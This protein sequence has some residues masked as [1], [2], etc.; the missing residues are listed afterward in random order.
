MKLFD[1]S[2]KDAC[3]RS[4]TLVSAAYI[5]TANC[6]AV[7]ARAYVKAEG[8]EHRKA[9]LTLDKGLQERRGCG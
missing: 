4:L 1:L 3:F 5:G 6:S 9:A 2:F 8:S 7:T